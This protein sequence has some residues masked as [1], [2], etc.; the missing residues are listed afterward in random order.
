MAIYRLNDFKNLLA[1]ENWD[2]FNRRRS[3]ATLDKLDWSDDYFLT[4]LNSLVEEDFQKTVS[5]CKIEDYP[6]AEYVDADQYVVHWDVDE[7]VRRQLITGSTLSL[8]LK[9]AIITNEHGQ[10]AGVVTIH[11]SGS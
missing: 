5:N 6:F 8:S 3:I 11:T 9:I 7:H 2:Y 1:T 4:F 10:I